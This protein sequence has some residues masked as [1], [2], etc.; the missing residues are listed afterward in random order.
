M[1]KNPLDKKFKNDRL[2]FGLIKNADLMCKD[3]MYRYDDS[4]VFGNTS[5]CEMYQERKPS[6]VLDGNECW[7]YDKEETL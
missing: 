2:K 5:R 1:N 3:C 7:L 4:Q 6:E